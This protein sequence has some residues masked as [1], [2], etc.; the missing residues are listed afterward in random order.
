MGRENI[1][2]RRRSSGATRPEPTR[3]P[4]SSRAMGAYGRRTQRRL[5]LKERVLIVKKRQSVFNAWQ[6]ALLTALLGCVL[7]AWSVAD[8]RDASF[9]A[10]A[11]PQDPRTVFAAEDD[12]AFVATFVGDIMLGRDTSFVAGQLGY[13]VLFQKTSLLWTDADY[14][15]G[16]LECTLLDDESA[17]DEADKEEHFWSSDEAASALANAGFTILQVANNHT[18]DYGPEG[19]LHTLEALEKSGID[20]VG[21]GKDL[22]AA[23]K[24]VEDSY[25]PLVVKTFAASDIVPARSDAGKRSAGI[26]SF[27]TGDVYQAIADAR[28]GADLIVVGAHWGFDYARDFSA[29][30][31]SMAH[32]LID[33][34]ADIVVG[35][36]A[37]TLEPIELYNGGIIF[38]GLGNFVSDDAWVRARDSV[39]VRYTVDG[40]GASSFE[41]SPL[42]IVSGIPQPTDDAI[43]IERDWAVLTRALDE[44]DYRIESGT[45]TI[46]FKTIDVSED[47]FVGDLQENEEGTTCNG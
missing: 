15:F 37:H 10:N 46:P 45:L 6:T 42:R 39:V 26:L 11:D 44:A 21:A 23:Q 5:N 4:A 13:D 24:P 17:Y 8:V 36:H 3:A 43:S 32:S 31:Q 34:G 2:T 7:V 25:G 16:N 35:T 28:D 18:V 14:V 1:R 22:A 38:Y 20:V 47:P 33:A 41:I 12:R 9:A 29:D 40:G 27:D 30:Q 19:L